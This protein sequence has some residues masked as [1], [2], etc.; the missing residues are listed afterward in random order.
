MV[1]DMVSVI[2][3]MIEHPEK[4][5]LA[6]GRRSGRERV[7]A[8]HTVAAH[9]ARHLLGNAQVRVARCYRHVGP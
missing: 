7:G 5:R 9:G 1:G 8:P 2:Y 3:P 4:L 6:L